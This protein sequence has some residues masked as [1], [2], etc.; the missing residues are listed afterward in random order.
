VYTL[1][2]HPLEAFVA[3]IKYV[4]SL[5]QGG[6]NK[7]HSL[8]AQEYLDRQAPELAACAV[9][10]AEGALREVAVTGAHLRGHGCFCSCCRLLILKT[11]PAV[12]SLP[13]NI[14]AAWKRHVR[15]QRC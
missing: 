11:S 5:Y 6:C 14:C 2:P 10:K 12:S 1:L 15:W 8:F 3:D 4:A 7:A 9:S 13:C